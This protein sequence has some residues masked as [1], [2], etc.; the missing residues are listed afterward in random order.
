[1]RDR[2]V[3]AWIGL[4]A[5]LTYFMWS[6]WQVRGLRPRALEDALLILVTLL[7]MSALLGYLL[8]NKAW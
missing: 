1:V 5:L 8:W 6:D 4:A 2:L 3:R 7:S